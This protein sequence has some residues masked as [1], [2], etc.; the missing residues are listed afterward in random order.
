MGLPGIE[1]MFGGALSLGDLPDPGVGWPLFLTLAVAYFAM[2]YLLLGS[3]FLAIGSLASTVREV[4]TLSMPVTMLQVFLFL[5]ATLAVSD[6]GG[7]LEWTAMAFPFS[8]P[9]AMLARAAQEQALWPHAAALAW[10]AF[11][12][13]LSIRLGAALFRKRVM[14]SGPQGARRR[15]PWQRAVAPVAARAPRA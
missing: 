4:Q 11:W 8:S 5:F 6:R 9:F 2:G 10:Q 3:V 15:R 7:W 14:K 12:V 1:S 13:L